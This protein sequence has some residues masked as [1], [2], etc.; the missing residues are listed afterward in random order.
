MITRAI[1]LAIPRQIIDPLIKRYLDP[2]DLVAYPKCLV[3][4]NDLIQELN[5]KPS[6]VIGE[7]LTEIQIAQ[8]ESKIFTTQQAID[9]ARSWMQSGE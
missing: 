5:L 7:L 8:I 2:T 3:T 6:P 4:G 1:S 9:F